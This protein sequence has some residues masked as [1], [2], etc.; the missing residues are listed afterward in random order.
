[1]RK[2]FLIF[3]LLL[4]TFDFSKQAFACSLNEFVP[5]K[6]NSNEYVFFGK[7][8]GYSDK[9]ETLIESYN[10]KIPFTGYGIIVKI[11]SLVNLPQNH[12]LIEVF[13]TGVRDTACTPQGA[14]L[15]SLKKNFPINTNVRVIGQTNK[16]LLGNTPN[17]IPRIQVAGGNQG[18]LFNNLKK[19]IPLTT[20]D[21]VFDYRLSQ[22]LYGSKYS[23]AQT[24][25]WLFEIRKDL[26]RLQEAKSEN[27]KYLILKRL[28]YA[29]DNYQDFGNLLKENVSDKQKQKE[30]LK[31]KKNWEKKRFS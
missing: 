2:L 27:E 17:L 16:N 9:A 22:P 6:F 21:S 20:V 26:K 31:I 14:D 24:F 15:E 13:P 23:T 3:S 11:E 7:V 30:L 5:F 8:I 4:I 29:Y 25:V 12:E 19:N 18:Q 1:M 10:R 28:A